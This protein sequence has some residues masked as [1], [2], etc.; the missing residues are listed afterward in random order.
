MP[1]SAYDSHA[2]RLLSA[3]LSDALEV[4]RATLGG[5]LTEDEASDFTKK[6]AENLLRVF[7]SGERDPAALKQAALEGIFSPVS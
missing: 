2:I 6:L 7:D 5:R 3:A 1:F 4:V